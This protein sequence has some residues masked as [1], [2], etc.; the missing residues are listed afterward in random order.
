MWVKDRGCVCKRSAGLG[1]EEE[2]SEGDEVVI[3]NDAIMKM[4]TSWND[5]M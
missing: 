2:I 5:L 3:K 4:A 1:D